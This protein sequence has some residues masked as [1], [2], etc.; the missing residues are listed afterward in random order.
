MQLTRDSLRR[1]RVMVAAT[2]V[3]DGNGRAPIDET[4]G[5]GY[6]HARPA[7]NVAAALSRGGAQQLQP[8]GAV[9]LL[10]RCFLAW[11]A[12]R[13]GV[14]GTLQIGRSRRSRAFL[15]LTQCKYPWPE[16]VSS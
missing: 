14:P 8:V 16:W 11:A 9:T 3:S 13:P 5:R 7:L 1:E 6:S 4:A 15:S 12:V 2:T 10:L